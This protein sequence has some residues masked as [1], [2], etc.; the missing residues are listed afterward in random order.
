MKD[1]LYV[2]CGTSWEC[3]LLC[4]SLFSCYVQYVFYLP[5]PRTVFIWEEKN[6]KWGPVIDTQQQ[7]RKIALSIESSMCVCLCMCAMRY[8]IICERYVLTWTWLRYP[9]YVPYFAIW[10][11]KNEEEGNENRYKL[12]RSTTAQLPFYP[13]LLQ[14]FRFSIQIK[15]LRI[16]FKNQVTKLYMS[17]QFREFNKTYYYC[18]LSV[19]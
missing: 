3:A 12:W 10:Q 18:V 5:I 13:P 2:E 17:R 8:P 9:S 14:L 1:V 4:H 19:Q 15:L 11:K 7:Q 6:L 16:E